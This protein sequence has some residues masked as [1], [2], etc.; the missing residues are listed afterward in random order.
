MRVDLRWWPRRICWLVT[1]GD[2]AAPKATLLT[3]T[4]DGCQHSALETEA[5]SNLSGP[6]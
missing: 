6:G 1:A 5:L 4:D 2:D 3:S